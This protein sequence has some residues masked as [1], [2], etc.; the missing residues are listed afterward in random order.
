MG[1][2]LDGMAPIY[3]NRRRLANDSALF[4]QFFDYAI[5]N[6]YLLYKHSCHALKLG[7]KDLLGFRLDLV[8]LLL[9]QAGPKRGVVRACEVARDAAQSARV[10]ELDRVSNIVDLKRGKYHYCQIKEEKKRQHYTS[11]GCSVLCRLCR[12][13]CFAEF[14][15]N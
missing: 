11:L 7:A 13:P 8:H 1:S 10:C 2:D 6:A 14:H 9:E 4:F 15:R 3:P 12:T 5:N